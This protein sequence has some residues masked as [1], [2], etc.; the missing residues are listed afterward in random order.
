MPTGDRRGRSAQH[1]QLGPCALFY[2]PI[3][4]LSPCSNGRL[5]AVLAGQKRQPPSRDAPNPSVSCPCSSRR[6]NQ[7]RT[8]TCACVLRRRIP[9]P[10]SPSP[11]PRRRLSC[12]IRA[13]DHARA[14]ARRF[15]PAQACPSP[16]S[17]LLEPLRR[18]EAVVDLFPA[19][20]SYPPLV[21]RCYD[22]RRC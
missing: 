8:P 19:G 7:A 6:K 21:S 22:R 14:V 13:N 11:S 4:R 5:I 18:T 3:C 17:V 9:P 2:A 20:S 12:V 1:I 15:K 10:P 16:P